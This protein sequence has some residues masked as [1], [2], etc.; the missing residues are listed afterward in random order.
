VLCLEEDHDAPQKGISH[1]MSQKLEKSQILS[2]Y[3]RFK[4]G[5]VGQGN[6]LGFESRYEAGLRLLWQVFLS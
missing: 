1:F 3:Y 5:L 6:S 2:G 4:E